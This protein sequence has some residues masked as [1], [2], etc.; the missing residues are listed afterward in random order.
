MSVFVRPV[1]NARL[2][3]GPPVGSLTLNANGSF[4]YTPP[5]SFTGKV[6]FAYRANDG[7]AD[8]NTVSVTFNVKRKELTRFRGMLPSR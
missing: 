8:S 2:V 4:T 1:A 7:V 6:S 5:V 3:S